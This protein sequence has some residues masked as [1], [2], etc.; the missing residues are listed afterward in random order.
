MAPKKTW[1]WLR[2]WKRAKVKQVKQGKQ[3]KQKR[4]LGRLFCELHEAQKASK[5][6]ATT[7]SNSRRFN[8]HAI[9]RALAPSQKPQPKPKQLCPLFLCIQKL[10]S[11]EFLGI[12]QSGISFLEFL[13]SSRFA[14]QQPKH[15]TRPAALL[16]EYL[17][18]ML[19]DIQNANPNAVRVH[20]VAKLT[21]SHNTGFQVV[22]LFV[23]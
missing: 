21:G 13:R 15:T 18:L 5:T 2:L 19:H 23:P 20:V 6:S 11:L 14:S 8:L 16:K 1:H 9:C 17:A 12:F 4:N 3:V 22:G 7:H 10:H